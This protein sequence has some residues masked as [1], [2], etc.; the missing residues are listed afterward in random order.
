LAIFEQTQSVL[1]ICEFFRWCHSVE[2]EAGRTA[3]FS[4]EREEPL[5]KELSSRIV[6]HLHNTPE[7]IFVTDP[8]N[9]LVYLQFG[10]AYGA[11]DEIREYLA[12]QLAA[13]PNSVTA[14]LG[15]VLGKAWDVGTG[16]PIDS[17]FMGQNYELLSTFVDSSLIAEAVRR[18][19]GPE[20]DDPAFLSQSD[21][22]R[23]LQLAARFMKFFSKKAVDPQDHPPKD[24][25]SSDD[26]T[27]AD[28]NGG[29]N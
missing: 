14:W 7:P 22:D 8:E 20:A 5:K 25:H 6:N 23:D 1:F 26:E 9:A 29:A 18:K 12:D 24:A 4:P 16:M 19:Y 13:K 11:A 2:E 21:G 10:H 3:M 15:A 28:E 17:P 27:T